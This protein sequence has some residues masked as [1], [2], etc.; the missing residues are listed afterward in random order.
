MDEWWGLEQPPEKFHH[1]SYIPFLVEKCTYFGGNS[2]VSELAGK[3]VFIENSTHNQNLEI[4]LSGSHQ[5]ECRSYKD[6]ST[7]CVYV[8]YYYLYCT[9]PWVHS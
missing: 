6:Y 7:R 9:L 4:Y 3:G 8:H 1:A 5:P 2:R